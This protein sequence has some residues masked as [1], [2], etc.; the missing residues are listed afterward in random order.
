MTY[1]MKLSV[2]DDVCIDTKTNKEVLLSILHSV[3]SSIKIKKIYLHI[4][5]ADV[6]FI[7][8]ESEEGITDYKFIIDEIEA[9]AKCY[10]NL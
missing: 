2:N 10:T 1:F 8:F 5:S 4:N 3:L 9:R 7:H 6:Q